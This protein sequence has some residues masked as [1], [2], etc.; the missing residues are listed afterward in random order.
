M[1]GTRAS[2]QRVSTP[3]AGDRP[4]LAISIC[5]EDVVRPY[6]ISIGYTGR[7]DDQPPFLLPLHPLYCIVDCLI[8]RV[9]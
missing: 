9:I 5:G 7:S 3:K 2:D 1:I 8:D 6:D 4:R